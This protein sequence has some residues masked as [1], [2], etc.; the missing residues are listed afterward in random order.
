[1]WLLVIIHLSIS[2]ARAGT[3][4]LLMYWMKVILV[5]VGFESTVSLAVPDV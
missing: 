5:A 4:M 2:V 3:D 1:M